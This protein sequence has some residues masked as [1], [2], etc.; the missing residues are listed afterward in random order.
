VTDVALG[1][2][3]PCRS[4]FP[5]F[6]QLRPRNDISNSLSA[7]PVASDAMLAK[8]MIWRVPSRTTAFVQ[9]AGPTPSG[10]QT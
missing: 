4:F 2:S 8:R 3:V 1:C 7:G 10:T 5:I 6:G 9:D